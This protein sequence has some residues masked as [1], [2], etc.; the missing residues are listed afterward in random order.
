MSE[1]KKICSKVLRPELLAMDAYHVPPSRGL[2]KLDV[3]ENPYDFSP[4][5]KTR[6][7][8]KLK[9]V[10][11]NRYPEAMPER[12]STA[13]ISQTGLPGNFKVMLGNGSD[14]L[15][16][17][18]IQSLAVSAGPVMSVSPT[19]S[20]Y[21]ILARIIGKQYVEL[22]LLDDFSLDYPSVLEQI[23]ILNPACIFLAYPNNPTGNLFDV[24]QLRNI[25]AG[26]SG[27]VVIDEAYMPFAGVTLIDWLI[28]FP[29]LLVMRT[30]SK[31]GLA[32]LRFGMLFGHE[33][34]LCELDKIRLPF[35][36][37]SLTQASV[38]FA[39][40]NYNFFHVNAQKIVEERSRVL[41]IL[42][43]MPGLDV[44]PSDANFILFRSKNLDAVQ[45]FDSLLARKI[46][47]KCLHI[48]DTLLDQCLRV[49]IG[50]F[51]END[52]FLDSMRDILKDTI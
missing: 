39:L 19:F 34:W 50:K 28:E 5:L 17:I 42:G 26:A 22:P 48:P 21:K 6:W 11:I 10:S 15:I 46:L 29:N 24:E 36:V 16:Q 7:A 37:N 44:F 31:A 51:D 14:E 4:Q 32:G 33:T 13:L 9:Q 3:M 27:L 12:L 1:Y 8:D 49:T 40:E 18:I 43:S 30:L 23:K 41:R 20:M 47:I 25:V 45:I 35:N 2:V 52:L 38:E